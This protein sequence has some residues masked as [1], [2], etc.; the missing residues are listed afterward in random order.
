MAVPSSSSYLWPSWAAFLRVFRVFV[1]RVRSRFPWPRGTHWPACLLRQLQPWQLPHRHGV[2]KPSFPHDGKPAREWTGGRCTARWRSPDGSQRGCRKDESESDIQGERNLVP[3]G[4]RSVGTGN[5]RKGKYRL[6]I[7][8]AWAWT[9]CWR[10]TW[11]PHLT[12]DPYRAL[13]ISCQISH[14]KVSPCSSI[15]IG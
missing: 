13:R 4:S 8:T 1:T 2:L 3:E 6:H 11:S 14:R 15:R 12:W 5:Q 7:S 9:K 10:S